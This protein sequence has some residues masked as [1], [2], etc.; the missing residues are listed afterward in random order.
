MLLW[1]MWKQHQSVQT[2]QDLNHA[3]VL[4]TCLYVHAPSSV[5]P[6]VYS[7][8]I[9]RFIIFRL[10]SQVELVELCKRVMPCLA[11]DN[12]LLFHYVT[13]VFVFFC[14]GRRFYLSV[15]EV[16]SSVLDRLWHQIVSRRSP[17]ETWD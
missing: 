10:V 14:Q 1:T 7:L 16:V 4:D 17:G 9:E 2:L 15:V 12:E 6:F 8:H 13:V 5:L 3:L 11:A